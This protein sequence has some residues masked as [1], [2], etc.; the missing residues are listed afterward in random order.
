MAKQ[1]NKTMT[2]KELN[3]K[4]YQDW[5]KGGRKGETE[6]FNVNQRRYECKKKGGTWVWGKKRGSECVVKKGSPVRD[7]ISKR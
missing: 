4:S 2:N 6:T 1:K 5:V 3:E 7:P